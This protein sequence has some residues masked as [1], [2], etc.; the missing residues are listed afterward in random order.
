ME[1]TIGY[2]DIDYC[3]EGNILWVNNEKQNTY[4]LAVETHEKKKII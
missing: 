4:T 3:K 1:Y 2:I